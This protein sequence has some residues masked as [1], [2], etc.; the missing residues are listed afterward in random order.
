MRTCPAGHPCA[1]LTAWRCP[2]CRAPWPPPSL[3]FDP[4]LIDGGSWSLARYAALLPVRPAVTLGEGGTPLVPV[5][6]VLAKLEFLAPTGSFKDRGTALVV[7]ALREHGVRSVVEDSSGNAGASLA[8]YAAAAGM[9]ARVFVPEHASPAKKRQIAATGATVVEVPGGRGAAGA[10]CRAAADAEPGVVYA[11]HCWQPA[12]LAGQ[13]TVA[14]ELW[15]QLGRRAPGAVVCP[16]GQGGLL[17]GLWLGF[18]ALRAAG[19]VPVLPRLYAVQSA[20]CAPLARAWAAGSPAP[21]VVE[22]GRTLAEGIR[23]AAPV[24]GAL[25]LEALRATGGG[26]V[27]VTDEQIVAAHRELAARGLLVEPT[28]A[29]AMA[30]LPALSLPGPG[31]DAVS[32]PVPGAVPGAVPGPV[33]VALTGSGLK[34]L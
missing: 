26:A 22:E 28:S 34:A 7:S 21:A 3:A 10:A 24:R 8:A 12:F 4:A 14:W 2:A 19:L 29:A 5:G 18:S 23:T 31:S 17:L 20:A 33:V 16:V 6:G 25:V 9:R 30:A 1:D 27:A 11:S 32:D 13:T 15:E